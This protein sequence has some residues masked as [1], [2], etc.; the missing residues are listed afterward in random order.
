MSLKAIAA[1]S[2]YSM[3]AVFSSPRSDRTHSRRSRILPR[4][5]NAPNAITPRNRYAEERVMGTCPKCKLR[6]RKNGNHLKLGSVWFHKMCPN[7]PARPAKR[8]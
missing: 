3:S 8:A 1:S 4:V 2:S 7:K 5:Y 6:I